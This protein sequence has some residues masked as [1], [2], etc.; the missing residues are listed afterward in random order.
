LAHI[1]PIFVH[2]SIIGPLSQATDKFQSVS[3]EII[4]IKSDLDT[5][6]PD[7]KLGQL[8]G[9]VQVKTVFTRDAPDI[10]PAG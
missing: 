10:R 8:V 1:L 4:Q 2:L 5:Q 6:H 7:T 9:K 3:K